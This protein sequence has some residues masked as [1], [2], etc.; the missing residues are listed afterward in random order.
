MKL[1]KGL[2][3]S[4]LDSL[5]RASVLG[6]HLVVATFMGLAIGYYLDKWLETSPLFTM[7][8]LF[9][10]IIAGF[11]NMYREVKAIRRGEK[12]RGKKEQQ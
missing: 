4:Y 1:F 5:F 8:F 2:D 10:G 12:K 3:R 7:L 9:F 6:I 11:Q